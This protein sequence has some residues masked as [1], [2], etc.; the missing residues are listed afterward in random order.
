MAL[1]KIAQFNNGSFTAIV[2]RDVELG[3]YRVSFYEEGKHMVSGDY[4]TDD[5]FDALNTAQCI[6]SRLSSS[7]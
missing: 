6:L 4:H 7:V 3:E 5:K 2:R 1:R